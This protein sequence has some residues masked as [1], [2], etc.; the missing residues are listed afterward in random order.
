MKLKTKI[1]S[2]LALLI[3]GF[4]YYYVE[5]SAVNIHSVD[6]WYFII[7][8]IAVVTV[9]YAVRKRISPS[10]VK[11]SKMMKLMIGLIGAVV[12]VFLVGSLLSSQIDY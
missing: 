9:I 3:A 2:V 11:Q 4:V 5:P 1:L 10:E 7:F 6:F 12:V 8:G